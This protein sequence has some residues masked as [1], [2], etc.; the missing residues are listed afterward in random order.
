MYAGES[1]FTGK[2]TDICHFRKYLAHFYARYLAYSVFFK[3]GV[4]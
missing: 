4:S 2:V 3:L 1:Q